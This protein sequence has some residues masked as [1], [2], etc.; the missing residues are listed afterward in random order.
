MYNYIVTHEFNLNSYAYYSAYEKCSTTQT[1]SYSVINIINV[2][3]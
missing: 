2:Y 3:L 1:F